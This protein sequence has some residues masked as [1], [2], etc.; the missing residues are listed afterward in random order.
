MS[1]TRFDLDH[2]RTINLPRHTRA[3]GEVVVAE[4]AAVPFRIERLF[5]LTAPSAVATRTGSAR[6]S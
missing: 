1:S 4:E 5:T 2:V 3:D 6:S